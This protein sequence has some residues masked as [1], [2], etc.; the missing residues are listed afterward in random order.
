MSLPCVKGGGSRKRDG[1]IVNL[2]SKVKTIPQ[3]PSV[4]AP[5]TQGSRICAVLLHRAGSGFCPILSQRERRDGARWA[6]P[7]GGGRPR[8]MLALDASVG[9]A[10]KLKIETT[11]KYYD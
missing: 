2:Q 7:F 4:T 1:G 10:E 9:K 8:A 6:P 11:E 3:S 5:F